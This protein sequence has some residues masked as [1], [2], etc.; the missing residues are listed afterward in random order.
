MSLLRIF[1]GEA[2]DRLE[3]I[4]AKQKLEEKLGRKVS[5]HELYS[6]TANIEAAQSAPAA[7]EQSPATPRKPLS[8]TTRRVLLFGGAALVLMAA[9]FLAVASMSERT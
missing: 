4:R 3:D 8:K 6:L 7:A 5:D 1:A 2:K 9:A